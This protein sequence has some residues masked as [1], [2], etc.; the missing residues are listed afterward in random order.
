MSERKRFCEKY[1]DLCE[2][3]YFSNYSKRST[4]GL[5]L[6]VK[7]RKPSEPPPRRNITDVEPP[8]RRDFRPVDEYLPPSRRDFRP[9]Q[10]PPRRDFRPVRNNPPRR[11]FR[12]VERDT[13]GLPTRRKKFN[14]PEQAETPESLLIAMKEGK[15]KLK[16]LKVQGLSK[17]GLG[18][19]VVKES[20]EQHKYGR[21]SEASYRYGYGDK[22]GANDVISKGDY[23]PD[24]VDFEIIDPLSTKDY[25]TLRNKTTGE[26]VMSFRGSDTK[27]ADVKTLME[28]PSR[29]T[30]VEDW[31]VNLHTMM[32]NPEKT[33]RYKSSTE[34][35]RNVARTLGVEP[36]DIVFT[37]HSNGGGNARRQAEI[38]G[39]EA[40]TFNGADNPL[41]DMSNPEKLGGVKEGAR[42]KAYRT[43]GDVV[44]A[45][46]ESKTPDHMEVERLT[47]KAGTETNLIEQH[48]VDQFFHD[49]PKINSSGEIEN[50]R[51]SKLKNFLG[52]AGGVAGKSVLGIAGA[53]AFAP[54]YADKAVEAKEQAFLVADTGKALAFEGMLDPGATLLDAIDTMGMG[55]LPEEKK[56]IRKWLGVKEKKPP[57]SKP[58]PLITWLSKLTG[59]YEQ[60][61]ELERDREMA[62]EMGLTLNEYLTASHG[63]GFTGESATEIT[64]EDIDQAQNFADVMSGITQEQQEQIASQ[65]VDDA[66]GS[67]FTRGGVHYVEVP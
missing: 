12:P 33:Q 22:A 66:D 34:A 29:A 44:S 18:N 27:F 3:D 10:V 25:T 16:E 32:G 40:V 24:M 57:K 47:A 46:H 41:K 30:N 49:N 55:L 19:E 17:I 11:D 4:S 53:E 28:D 37:G 45:G 8:P 31:W 1:P 54:I 14:I 52:T 7:E 26:V 50:V 20:I 67:G 65:D 9:I 51:T 42:V 58:P 13:L 63:R 5:G 36:S 60:D 64:Q 62:E 56:H 23:I 2:K 59:R 21:L 38:F 39:A 15:E 48:G 6:P 61:Q 43:Y 35:V